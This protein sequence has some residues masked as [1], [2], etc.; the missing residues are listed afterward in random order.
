[1][2]LSDLI[3]RGYTFCAAGSALIGD[4]NVWTPLATGYLGTHVPICGERLFHRALFR[5]LKGAIPDNHVIEHLNDKPQ[6]NRLDNLVVGTQKSN[7]QNQH[8]PNRSNH[9]TGIRGVTY[10]RD[11]NKYKA[12]IKTNGKWYNLGRY[13]TVEEAELAA[14]EGRMKYFE[15]YRAPEHY[16]ALKA[17]IRGRI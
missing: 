3:E 15:H 8:K 12:K 16:E 13:D 6:D 9:S 17:M 5:I 4:S 11:R 7:V 1:M 14:I 10:E 2:K